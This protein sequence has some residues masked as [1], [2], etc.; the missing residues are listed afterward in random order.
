MI[1][2]TLTLDR[3]KKVT[4]NH[5]RTIQPRQTRTKAAVSRHAQGPLIENGLRETS[6]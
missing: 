2:S 3:W 4:D 6:A 1:V 5:L